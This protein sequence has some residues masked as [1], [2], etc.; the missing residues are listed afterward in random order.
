MP[1]C[2]D[3]LTMVIGLF[4]ALLTAGCQGSEGWESLILNP[5]IMLSVV[6]SVCFEAFL[7]FDVQPL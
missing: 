3:R 5:H 7:P 1:R 4:P 6:D 2:M